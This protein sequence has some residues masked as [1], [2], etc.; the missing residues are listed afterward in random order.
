[1]GRMGDSRLCSSSSES[2][3]SLL[4]MGKYIMSLGAGKLHP[5]SNKDTLV[6]GMHTNILAYDVDN[7][8]DVFYKEVGYI[9]L[10]GR[11]T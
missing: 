8:S 1:M 5:G 3:I 9:L 10:A 2:D 4:T 7:N 6:V 11:N